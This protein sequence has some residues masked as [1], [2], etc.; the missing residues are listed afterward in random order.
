[1][2]SS[3]AATSVVDVARDEEYSVIR[4]E[5]TRRRPRPKSS[6]SVRLTLSVV[7]M[8]TEMWTIGF[9]VVVVALIVVFL[10]S[11][12][13]TFVRTLRTRRTADASEGVI[14]TL[15]TWKDTLRLTSTSLIEG[16]EN[17]T[18]HS[19]LGLKASIDDSDTVNERL[20]GARLGM[21][22]APTQLRDRDLYLTVEGPRTL[23][24]VAVARKSNQ[25]STASA[26]GFAALINETATPLAVTDP[27]LTPPNPSQ[28]GAGVR[29][30]NAG[31][32]NAGTKESAADFGMTFE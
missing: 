6:S 7:G 28:S 9:G 4:I 21:I 27:A 24:V 16:Y 22:S 13:V 10:V 3:A 17:G 32:P 25:L 29:A 15:S 2:L 26:R 30:E 20:S 19:L 5:R 8:R 18:V 14:A 23:L 11:F 12:V 1:M 31:A